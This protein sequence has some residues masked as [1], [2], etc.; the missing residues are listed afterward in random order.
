MLVVTW[1]LG[2][3]T[4]QSAYC[5]LKSKTNNII[6]WYGL[7]ALV[8]IVVI[9]WAERIE[10]KSARD[11]VNAQK[12]GSHLSW[13]TPRRMVLIG[14]RETPPWPK[15]L[16]CEIEEDW[17]DMVNAQKNDSHHGW[18][19]T[20]PWPKKL[21][22]ARLIPSMINPSTISNLLYSRVLIL[23]GKSWSFTYLDST[24]RIGYA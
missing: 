6:I 4:G 10:M 15:K 13:R 2:I 14:W 11:I 7:S 24:N 22:C 1:C 5:Q 16:S 23:P 9:S 12:N 21:S 8:S 20:A 3:Q 18:R 17:D 19:E